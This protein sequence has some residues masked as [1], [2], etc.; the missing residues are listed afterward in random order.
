MM[1]LELTETQYWIVAKAMVELTSE[2]GLNR[3]L[4]EFP[5]MD[6]T[7]GTQDFTAITEKLQALAPEG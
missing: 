1:Q 6:L 4:E 2:A 5:D 3:L 7:K